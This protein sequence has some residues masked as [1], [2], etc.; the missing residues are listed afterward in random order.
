MKTTLLGIGADIEE[1]AR[2]RMKKG[3]PFLKKVFKRD[4][5]RYCFSK[6]D[7]APHLAAR[8]CGKEAVL[9]ALSQLGAR[10]ISFADIEV[11]RARNGVLS[12]R[13][14]SNMKGY[15]AYVTL[16]HTR[17]LALGFAL[18]FKIELSSRTS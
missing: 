13:L 15:H 9:K 12:V 4:E 3:D 8:F 18:A 11:L 6:K 1:V 16:S 10:N 2:F 7:P 5:L 14:S 17:T